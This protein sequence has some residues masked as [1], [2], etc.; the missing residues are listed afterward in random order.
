MRFSLQPRGA[1]YFSGTGLFSFFSTLSFAL[2]LLLV[3]KTNSS[4]AR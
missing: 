1:P 4:Y 3:F 2:A